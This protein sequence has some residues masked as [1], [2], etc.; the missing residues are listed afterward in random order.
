MT[1]LQTDLAAWRAENPLRK[2]RESKGLSRGDVGAIIKKS[3]QAIGSYEGGAF[4]PSPEM[5]VVIATMMRTEVAV[6]DADWK[7]WASRQFKA[8]PARPSRKKKTTRKPRR[9]AS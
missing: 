4:N 9:R 5:M 7:L 3:P 8:P 6:L 2:W 1:K